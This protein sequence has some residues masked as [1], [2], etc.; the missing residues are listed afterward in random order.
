MLYISDIGLKSEVSSES[1][2]VEKDS[3]QIRSNIEQTPVLRH[4][5]K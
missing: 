4:E 3:G 5:N 1:L 2:V